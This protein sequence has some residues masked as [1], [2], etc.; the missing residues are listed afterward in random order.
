MTVDANGDPVGYACPPKLDRRMQND[1]Y[2][3]GMTMMGISKVL[4][5]ADSRY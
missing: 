1:Y 5:L 3:F 4:S 2:P